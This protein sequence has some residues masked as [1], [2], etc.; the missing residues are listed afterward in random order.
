MIVVGLTM[1][2]DA[3]PRP[4]GPE[5]IA[6]RPASLGDAGARILSGNVGLLL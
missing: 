5:P 2:D 1:G 4:G 6:P 3:S